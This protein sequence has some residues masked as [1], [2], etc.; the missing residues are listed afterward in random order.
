MNPDA[1]HRP[2]RPITVTGRM[3]ELAG[4]DDTTGTGVPATFSLRAV[5][6]DGDALAT[7]GP[8]TAGPD[9]SVE[10]TVPG[11]ATRGVN[12]DASADY[13]EV[14]ALQLVDAVHESTSAPDGTTAGSV[15]VLAAQTGP[16]LENSFVSSVEDG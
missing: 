5:N 9:G 2:G 11:S 10:V 8:F 6:A 14:V 3:F 7:F 1:V 16:V 4:D 15:P 12:P 13:R